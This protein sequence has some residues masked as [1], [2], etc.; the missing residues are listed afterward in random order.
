MELE[1][2]VI[3]APELPDGAAFHRSLVGLGPRRECVATSLAR[4]PRS[5]RHLSPP[6]PDEV[7]LWLPSSRLPS[8]ELVFEAPVGRESEIEHGGPVWLKDVR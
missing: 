7:R 8:L 6:R 5:A 1:Q 4:L 3:C 2:A